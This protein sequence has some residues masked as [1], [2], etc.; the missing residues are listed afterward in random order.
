MES[1]R[2]APL[3]VARLT[4][5]I[6][7]SPSG[8][9]SARPARR[10][11]T[12]FAFG[13]DREAMAAGRQRGQ[14][15]GPE[16]QQHSH[17]EVL[18]WAESQAKEFRYTWQALLSVPEGRLTP[19]DFTQALQ[20]GGLIEDWRLV[21]HDDTDYSHSHVLFFR[22]RRLDHEQ[23]TRWH[24]RV[25]DELAALEARHL[26]DRAPQQ[27]AAMPGSEAQQAERSTAWEAEL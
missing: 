1:E 24:D 7:R 4:Y 11:A 23:F 17:K 27:E 5:H 12:Y 8:R 21:V 14:W 19:T 9:H 25:R 18:E 26:E 10:W 16:G 15:Y 20:A 6:N 2:R 22:D 3:P 13:R